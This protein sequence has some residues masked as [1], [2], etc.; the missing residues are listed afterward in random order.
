MARA[1]YTLF[2]WLYRCGALVLSPFNVKARRWLAG[3]KNVF[4]NLQAYADGETKKII[5]FHCASLG[6]FEQ[7]RPLLE[8]IH[9]EYT[10]Y[11]ILLSFF[12]PSGYEIR[13]NFE[14]A[15]Y[16]TYLP[17]DS[18]ANAK[19]FLDLVKPAL[20][21]WVKYEYWFFYLKG[22]RQRNVPLL[23]VSGIF[24]NDQPF[25]KNWGGIYRDML[26]CFTYLFV[27][28]P[29]SKKLLGTIGYSDNVTVSGDTR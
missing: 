8:N 7:A 3:R 1:V 10:G 24:R 19:K 11:G 12:S 17:M 29:E 16:V 9:K 21:I 14:I 22:I 27:Q 5:W 26:G 6:E 20:V 4:G 15:S 2:L 25:F 18:E 28:N 23:L 13:K